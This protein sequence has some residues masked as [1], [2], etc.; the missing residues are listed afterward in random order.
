M[1]VV[2]TQH[3]RVTDELA[4]EQKARKH[5]ALLHNLPVRFIM[6]Y[7]VV[8]LVEWSVLRSF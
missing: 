6:I 5:T 8:L 7:Y 1:M 2:L 3:Q 4:D